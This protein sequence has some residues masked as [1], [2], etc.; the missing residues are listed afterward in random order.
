MSFPRKELSNK[1][2]GRP[3]KENNSLRD[4]VLREY[5]REQKNKKKNNETFHIE[6]K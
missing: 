5:W 6:V 4:R 1:K 2:P 3:H